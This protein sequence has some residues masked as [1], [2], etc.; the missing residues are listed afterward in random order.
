MRL[1]ETTDG[2][3]C[4]HER[5]YVRERVVPMKSDPLL[6]AVGREL[7][8]GETDVG[9]ARRVP[10]RQA[11]A[12]EDRRR[13]RRIQ[14]GHDGRFARGAA[15]LALAVHVSKCRLPAAL[16]LRFQV[17]RVNRYSREQLLMR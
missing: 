12:D 13:A 6:D 3:G 14:R 16:S 5:R 17:T 1:P 8:L 15:V 2:R 9:A 7:V 4:G 11:V 10:I